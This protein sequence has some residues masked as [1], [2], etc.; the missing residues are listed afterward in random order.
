MVSLSAETCLDLVPRSSR[1][2]I[3]LQTIESRLEF[4][5]L[6]WGQRDVVIVET[7]PELTDEIE[8][9]VGG[10]LGEIE[11]RAG[12]ATKC[13]SNSQCTPG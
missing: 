9:L 7:V 6:F 12:H 1:D 8:F 5:L 2:T 3:A 4:A 11:C 13:A 10:Q